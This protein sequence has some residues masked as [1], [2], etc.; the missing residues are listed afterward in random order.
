MNATLFDLPEALYAN[1][2][3]TT[4]LLQPISD[5]YN[6]FSFDVVN[7]QVAVI[8]AS[9]TWPQF[10]TY[11]AASI[12]VVL[13]G[14]MMSGLTVGYMSL[15]EL[16]LKIK[17][18]VG[19]PSEQRDA[20]KILPLI[21]KHHYLLVTLLFANAAAMEALP[22]FLDKLMPGYVAVLVSVTAVLVFGE[23][24]PQALCTGPYKLR[25]AAAFVEPIRMVMYILFLV[26]Y[27]MAKLLDKVIGEGDMLRQSYVETASIIET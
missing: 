15:D 9:L 2:N 12:V 16:S 17:I 20:K 14:G 11:L 22:L 19:T 27:P 25:I 24:I 18:Y 13:I 23:V 7:E 4:Y 6:L 21:K 26:A 1:I 3:G 8:P 5:P 10:L